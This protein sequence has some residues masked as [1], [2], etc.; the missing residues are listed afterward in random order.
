M[1]QTNPIIQYQVSELQELLKV[2]D[3]LKEHRAAT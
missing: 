2:S 3:S 1:E